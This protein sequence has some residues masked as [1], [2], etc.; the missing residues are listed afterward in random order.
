MRSH[1]F[2]SSSHSLG[3]L[4]ARS[5]GVVLL[6]P[7]IVLA[8]IVAVVALT[9]MSLSR[10]AAVQMPVAR[11]AGAARPLVLRLEPSPADA[12]L[13]RAARRVA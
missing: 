5:V 6:T 3:A 2:T 12:G 11:S 9:A 4:I 7:L 13:A 10:H 8:G 1:L